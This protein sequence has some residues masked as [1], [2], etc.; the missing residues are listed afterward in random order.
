MNKK[1]EIGLGG[2]ISLAIIMI[3]ALV[4]INEISNQQATMTTKNQATND[5]ITITTARLTANDINNSRGNFTI[6]SA[7][8]NG[9]W[10]SAGGCPV[11]LLAYGNASTNFTADTDYIFYP[12]TG[13]VNILNTTATK[14]SLP[15]ATFATYQYCQDGYI[16]DSGTRS[17]T[18]LILLM[19]IIGLLGVVIWKS[20]ILD[21]LN[22]SN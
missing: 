3:I 1:G 17:V 22:I 5:Q 18:G 14:T 16:E 11:T 15:N 7:P 4:L 2:I 12:N 10:Q 21:L 9:S 8:V 13:I 19:T 20:E 6:T